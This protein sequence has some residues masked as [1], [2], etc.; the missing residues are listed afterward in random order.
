LAAAPRYWPASEL[1]VRPQIMTHVM[2]QY[3]ADLP[4]GVKGRVVLELYVS[5]SGTLDRIRIVRAEP[6]GRFEQSALKAF[7]AAR[8]TPGKRKG[9]SVPSLVRIE[10]T[11]GD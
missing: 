2:P 1:D 9:K 3:P 8:F 4:A 5:S 6:P 7:T 11:F 10:V